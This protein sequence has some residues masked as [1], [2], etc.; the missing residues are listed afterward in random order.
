MEGRDELV[1]G[2]LVFWGVLRWWLGE[3]CLLACLRDICKI[4]IMMYWGLR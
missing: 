3:Y 2:S 4:C 1:L